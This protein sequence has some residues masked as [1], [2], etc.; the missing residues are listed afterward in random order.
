LAKEAKSEHHRKILE[1]M[2]KAWRKLAAEE[3]GES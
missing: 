1:E 2:A 3:D